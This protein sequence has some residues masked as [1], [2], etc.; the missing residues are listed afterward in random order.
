MQIRFE[1]RRRHLLGLTLAA[2]GVVIGYVAGEDRRRALQPG[3]FSE[4]DMTFHIVC[5]GP[6]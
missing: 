3:A 6:R 5:I 4:F 1:L 2:A